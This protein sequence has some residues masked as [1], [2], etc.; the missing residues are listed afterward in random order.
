ML[1]LQ[2]NL[3][4]NQSDTDFT[5]TELARTHEGGAARRANR[6][7]GV[8]WGL[9]P[10]GSTMPIITQNTRCRFARP[11][12]PALTHHM[13]T[14]WRGG[15]DVVEERGGGSGTQKMVYQKWPKAVFSFA[16]FIFSNYEIWV[17]G[18][19]GV[20]GVLPPPPLLLWLSTVPVHLWGSGGWGG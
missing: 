18:G 3:N 10:M 1:S 19:E 11:M 20:P 4:Q 17:Q 2:Q 6:R 12:C 8:I 13:Q 16:H 7:E 14:V 9:N 15:G 5:D